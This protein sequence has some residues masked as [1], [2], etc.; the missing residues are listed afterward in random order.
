MVYL[1]LNKGAV[2]LYDDRMLPAIRYDGSLL[3]KRVNLSME[4]V[5]GDR[6]VNTVVISAMFGSECGTGGCHC[7]SPTSI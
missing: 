2:R 4:I 6:C 5:F 1:T 3:A 7:G